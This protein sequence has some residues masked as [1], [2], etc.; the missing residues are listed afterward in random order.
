M[1]LLL[2]LLGKVCYHTINTFHTQHFFVLYHATT[3]V[4]HC[5]RS[6]IILY[7]LSSPG[8]Y[9][10][11]HRVEFAKISTREKRVLIFLRIPTLATLE[12][13]QWFRSTSVLY[14]KVPTAAITIT[15]VS[16]RVRA[17]AS[18]SLY[19]IVRPLVVA[20]LPTGF[21]RSRKK[22][23]LDIAKVHYDM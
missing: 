5:S 6:C 12:C 23:N 7:V 11:Q 16:W 21:M 3:V 18:E 1:K 19:N 13:W 22:Q 9:H 20:C 8:Y 2:F 10:Y 14:N 15:I 4:G 17:R